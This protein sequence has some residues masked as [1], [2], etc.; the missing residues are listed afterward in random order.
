[1]ESKEL[2]PCVGPLMTTTEITNVI[3]HTDGLDSEMRKALNKKTTLLS[4]LHPSDLDRLIQEIKLGNLKMAAE[5][6][7]RIS[8]MAYERKI[9]ILEQVWNAQLTIL[10][11]AM[12]KN[13]IEYAGKEYIKL[14]NTM[15]NN[16][17]ITAQEIDRQ[18]A[19]LNTITYEPLRN[20]YQESIDKL[21]ERSFTMFDELIERFIN[22]LKEKKI[23]IPD[24]RIIPA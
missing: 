18:I 10:G 19:K 20:R 21:C 22:D 7:R 11:V 2:V 13:V 6:T 24:S 23:D 14:M 4:R 5:Q 8:V 12:H 16:F 9:K 15:N 3:D 1:M 17:D